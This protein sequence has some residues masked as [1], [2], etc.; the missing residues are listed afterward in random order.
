MICVAWHLNQ[1][2][3]IERHVNHTCDTTVIV[4][5][6]TA[7]LGMQTGEIPDS[8]ISA[9]SSLSPSF[10]PANARLLATRRSARSVCNVRL[11]PCTYTP[12]SEKNDSFVFPYIYHSF[13]INFMKLSANIRKWICQLMAIW[14]WQNRLNIFCAVTKLWHFCKNHNSDD[15][16]WR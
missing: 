16:W 5:D 7:S 14:F 3:I 9:S 10:A 1:A 6:C 15:F 8:A 12:C 2:D 13:W 4:D 11:L